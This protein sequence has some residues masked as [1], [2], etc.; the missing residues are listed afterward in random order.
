MIEFLVG[1]VVL[2]AGIGVV[3]SLIWLY[4]LITMDSG[5]SLGSLATYIVCVAVVALLAC[6]FIAGAM[7]IGNELVQ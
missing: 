1:A 2:G 7:A 6:G 3:L 5:F 4:M